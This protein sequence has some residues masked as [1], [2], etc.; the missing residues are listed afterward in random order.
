MLKKSK[1]FTV[2]VNTVITI[3]TSQFFLDR[4]S[5]VFA[6][7]ISF[8]IHGLHKNNRSFLVGLIRWNCTDL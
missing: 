8:Y 4:D 7:Q 2:N 1:E 5:H 6:Q 3:E